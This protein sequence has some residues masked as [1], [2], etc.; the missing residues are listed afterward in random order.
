MLGSSP[1][2]FTPRFLCFEIHYPAAAINLFSGWGTA[3]SE[4]KEQPISGG[5]MGTISYRHILHSTVKL[6]I[7][8]QDYYMSPFGSTD[9]FFITHW[10]FLT[11]QK[12]TSPSKY[13]LCLNCYCT[14]L[15]TLE[16]GLYVS[17]T[18]AS[19]LSHC[20]I[21]VKGHHDDQGNSSNGKHLAGACLPGQ[22]V[23]PSSL[24][25]EADWLTLK[26]QLRA[27]PPDPQAAGR[28][29]KTPGL[30]WTFKTSKLTSFPH[31]Q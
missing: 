2:P 6:L 19:C 3:S 21:A 26:Q 25:Q 9:L 18:R 28:K 1:K 22:S 4:K 16:V 24:R 29:R 27:L 23:S 5:I 30:A 11:A 17:V 14:L 31:P 7:Y 15:H 20:S 12:F 8:L 10:C 13:I